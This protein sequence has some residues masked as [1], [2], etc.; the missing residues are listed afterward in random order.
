MNKKYML[1]LTKSQ[2]NKLY[3][4]VKENKCSKT[5]IGVR[6]QLFDLYVKAND[7]IVNGGGA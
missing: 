1:Y 4:L 3:S 6:K 7:I 5:P 2:I